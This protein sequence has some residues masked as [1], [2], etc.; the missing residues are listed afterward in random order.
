MV[1][2]SCSSEIM[3]DSGAIRLYDS[4][5]TRTALLGLCLLLPHG[6]YR[7]SSSPSCPEVVTVAL[8]CWAWAHPERTT[9]TLYVAAVVTAAWL[10]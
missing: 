6:R 3:V 7:Y 5:A 4:R 2:V 8:F 9:G 1:A 10:L